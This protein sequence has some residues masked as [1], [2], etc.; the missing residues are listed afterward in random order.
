MVGQ[1]G[2]EGRVHDEPLLPGSCRLAVAT[3]PE[4]RFY[5]IIQDFGKVRIDFC[6]TENYSIRLTSSFN[7]Q[8]IHVT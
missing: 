2:K 6:Q 1:L 4:Q 3:Q 5:Y 8:Q 7:M